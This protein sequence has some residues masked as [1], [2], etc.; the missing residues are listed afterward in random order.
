MK[1]AYIDLHVH[2]DGTLN[3]MWQ[4]RQAIKVGLIEESLTFSEYYDKMHP[5]RDSSST[6]FDKFD[7][8]LDVMQDQESIH[9]AIYEFCREQS[10]LGV[11]YSEFRFGPSLLCKKGLT[12]EETVLAAIEGCKDGERDFGIKAK[13]VN[14]FLHR[15]DSAKVNHEGNHETLLVTKKYLGRYVVGVDLAGYENN[16]DLN[17]YRYLFDEARELG[18]P[19]TIHAGEMGNG[20]NVMKA[21]AMGTKRIGHGINAVQKEE[22]IKALLDNGITLEVC[23]TSNCSSFGYTY[24]NHPIHELYARGVKLTINTDDGTFDNN[25]LPYEFDMLRNIGFTDEQFLSFTMNAIDAALCSA[26]EKEELR[27]A[28]LD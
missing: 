28:V 23:P 24:A 26:E 6:M 5:G 1:K 20:E 27:K 9:D 8:P 7:M 2:L 19:F 3:L 15:G 4:Y 11:I 14:C 25:N 18:V 10:R 13:I 16:C 17:E 21:I 12:Q 22:Y